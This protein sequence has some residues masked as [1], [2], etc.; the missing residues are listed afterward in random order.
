MNAK[1]RNVLALIIAGNVI[2]RVVNL[3]LNKKGNRNAKIMRF[4]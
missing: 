4:Y 3:V 1:Q 2:L